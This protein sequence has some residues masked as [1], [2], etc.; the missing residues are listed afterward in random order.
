M[1]VRR[2]SV[3]TQLF[4]IMTA[5][6]IVA[7][8]V[9]GM[10]LYRRASG[11]MM[12]QIRENAANLAAC[13]AASIDGALLDSIE[14]GD[15]E[16]EAFQAVLEDLILFRDNAGIEYIYT[17]RPDS[18]LVAVFVVDS[19]PD[20]PAGIGEEFEWSDSTLAAFEGEVLADEVPYTDEWGTHLSAYAPVYDGSRIVGAAAVDLSFDWVEGQTKALIMTIVVV[21]I[22]ITAVSLLIIMLICTHL[23]A[24]F[25]R[26]NTKLV[27][28]TD[29]SGDLTREIEQ[30]SG[31]EFEVIAG[32]INTFTGQIRNL[33]RQV[34]GT[35]E[36]ILHSQESVQ[37]SIGQ[38][39]RTIRE[40]GD[41]IV[42]ISANME[43]CSASSESVST[44][45]AHA[46]SAVNDFAA[47]IGEVEQQTQQAALR[48]DDAAR[49]AVDHREK[50]LAEIQKLDEEIRSANEDAKS[51]EE[52]HEIATR[53]NEIAS[54]TK[55][56]SLNA[57]VEAARAGDQGKGFAVVA[58]EVEKM[59]SA[60][61]SAV[62]QISTINNNVVAAVE[63]LSASSMEM[64][65]YIG[66][67]V[68]GD[69][70]RFVN[71]GKDYG[72]TMQAVQQYM[73]DMR[74]QSAT[75]SSTIAG[76]NDNIGGITAAVNESAQMIEQLSASSGAIS[77]EIRSLEQTSVDNVEQTGRLTGDIRKYR[78]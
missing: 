48:A 46:S 17:L 7:N 32:H 31:D 73:R 13:A 18:D 23:R 27:D 26:L 71:I 15:E 10:I 44:E 1:K 6:V 11:I 78:Y 36:N 52:V 43:E 33:V 70:D 51:I 53:I 77:E 47:Q 25:R 19:D 66:E 58:T 59:S 45:L 64:S 35:S 67:R 49:M 9:L 38:N 50:A 54:Q 4:L 20:E 72:D 14:E 57:Q 65:N 29:G 40:M 16:S 74:D 41:H 34:A 28:L 3:A 62:E 56:L 39:V 21:C 76:I 60:I 37:G 30:R 75:I 63:R 5:L 61:T 55:I 68:V 12:S 69:Y 22:I 2:I 8:V 42:S 24:S